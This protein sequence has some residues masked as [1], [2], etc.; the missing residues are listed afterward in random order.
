[1]F[2]VDRDKSTIVKVEDG[3]LNDVGE[4]KIVDKKEKRK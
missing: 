3:D 2:Y 1:M 4:N